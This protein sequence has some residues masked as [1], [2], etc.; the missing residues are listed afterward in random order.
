MTPPLTVEKESQPQFLSII[1]QELRE[2]VGQI[3]RLEGE[4]IEIRQEMKSIKKS[5]DAQQPAMDSLQHV[6][7]AGLVMRWVFIS[8]VGILSSLAVA[9]TAV[10]MIKI[11]WK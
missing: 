2:I 6:V 10:D 4:V 9:V 5:Q 11:V 7:S 1:H 8:S 3:R